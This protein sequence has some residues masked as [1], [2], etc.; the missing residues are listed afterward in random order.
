LTLSLPCDSA[1]PPTPKY[2]VAIPDRPLIESRGNIECLWNSENNPPIGYYMY[3]MYANLA[4]LN[5]LRKS[6][7][8]STCPRERERVTLA[9][10][11]MGM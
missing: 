7:G 8:M 5:E 9:K 1:V 11:G 3:Y 6:K 10:Q 4:T 2:W